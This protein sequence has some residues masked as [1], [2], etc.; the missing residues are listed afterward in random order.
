MH[1]ILH[2]FVYSRVVRTLSVIV[3]I[4]F[5]GALWYERLS[6]GFTTTATTVETVLMTLLAV[7][8]LTA[9]I[10]ERGWR[11]HRQTQD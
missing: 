11:K 9:Y 6:D 4:W 5:A 8:F 1:N 10:V 7:V 3:L 2:E